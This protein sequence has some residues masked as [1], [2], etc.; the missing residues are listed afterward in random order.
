MAKVL[1][2]YLHC[3]DLLQLAACGG[4]VGTITTEYSEVGATDS[5]RSNRQRHV[6]RYNRF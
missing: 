3:F 5:Q 1:K 6:A 4:L 2:S